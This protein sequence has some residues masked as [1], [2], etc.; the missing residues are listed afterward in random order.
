M[1]K[2]T[3]LAEQLKCNPSIIPVEYIGKATHLTVEFIKH[4]SYESTLDQFV[5]D[6][7]K[8][9]YDLVYNRAC[10]VINEQLQNNPDFSPETFT[11]YITPGSLF[12]SVKD[13][14]TLASLYSSCPD[15]AF[16]FAMAFMAAFIK[17]FK[18]KYIFVVNQ[19][20]KE[21][22]N[23]ILLSAVHRTL[24]KYEP[25]TNFSFS[26]LQQEMQAALYEYAGSMLPIPLG[27]NDYG[28]FLKI[29]K[30]VRYYNVN[31]S[32]LER[33]LYEINTEDD[34]ADTQR[35]F[36][37]DAQDLEKGF[38]V[39]L[40][41]AK[42]LLTIYYTTK[43][44]YRWY[45]YTEED[46]EPDT[47]NDIFGGFNEYKFLEIELKSF[48]E[49]VFPDENKRKAFWHLV[50]SE[51]S[52]FSKQDLINFGLTRYELSKMLSLLKD[53]LK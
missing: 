27:R 43:N 17:N 13:V 33:F 40:S 19:L 41:K 50:T 46:D 44:D 2:T 1:K 36:Q 12:Y 3:N 48:A 39:T 14:Q 34:L 45:A 22:V 28:Y 37:I 4:F 11:T 18:T 7:M 15:Q 52:T 9:D 29:C 51:H 5:T 49:S 30:Y 38:H 32:N 25:S 20:E 47:S 23:Q 26:Y 10:H 21:D 35:I 24:L 31:P 6:W 16:P 8:I 42:K 53:H